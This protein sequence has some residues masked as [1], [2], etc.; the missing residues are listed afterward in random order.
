MT[1]DFNYSGQTDYIMKRPLRFEAVFSFTHF[2]II[3]FSHL[4]YGKSSTF[5]GYRYIPS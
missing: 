3:T 1:G 5:N 2:H 4:Y